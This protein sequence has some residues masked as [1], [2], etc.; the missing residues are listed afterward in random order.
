MSTAARVVESNVDQVLFLALELSGSKWKV[1]ATVGLG[2]KPREKNVDAGD[3]VALEEEIRRAKARFELDEE[4]MVVSC[5]EAGRDGFWIHRALVSMG[6][7]NIVV[8]PASL[9]V[10]RRRK[11]RKTDRLD[12]AKLL[13]NLIRWWEGE[14]K[15]WSVVE[16]PE[17]EDEDA[18][19]LHRELETLKRERTR[20][21]NRIKAVLVSQGVR[22]KKINCG[23][24]HWLE[25]VRL[26]DG[27]N[28]PPQLRSR[29][30]REYERLES[31][32]GQIRE[33][34]RQRHEALQTSQ[35]ERIKKVAK[36][37]RLRGVG[38]NGS[39]LLVM[40][41][42]G[43]RVFGNRGQL[44]SFAGLTGTPYDS[45]GIDREQG[46][47]KAGNVRVRAVMIELAW[48]WLR[49]Q[50]QSELS[51][52][53]HS[54]FGS[55]GKRMR[56]VGIVALARKLLIAFWRYVEHDVVPGGAIVSK[57]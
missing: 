12:V 27:S 46:I 5:Y 2:Q 35:D 28:L 3:L 49:F 8:D 48:L 52:W 20:H 13:T 39:W 29:L 41:L 16:V 24:A 18:R 1:G 45:G 33:L 9:Q 44:G 25:H 14:D 37:K 40:E 57:P 21:I 42:F 15:V 31:V 30:V 23:F 32:T 7:R 50:P 26:W 10:N 11:R 22:L 56:K 34:E 51:R 55:T 43:W 6:V 54:R 17:V 36:L 47:D 38:P 19:Q 4:A 53:Y